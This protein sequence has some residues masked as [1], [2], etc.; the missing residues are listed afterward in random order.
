MNLLNL[1]S[2]LLYKIFF[3][4]DNI[5]IYY[6]LHSCY[7]FE[8]LNLNKILIPKYLI[9]NL[10]GEPYTN[11]KS[12]KLTSQAY[13]ELGYT[14]KEYLIDIAKL[15]DNMIFR[16]RI[17]DIFYKKFFKNT[18]NC[19]SNYSSTTKLESNNIIINSPLHIVYRIP[20]SKYKTFKKN[21][22]HIL[23]LIY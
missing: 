14:K 11:I 12:S 8:C 18:P 1:P 13:K 21:Y 15:I 10:Y 3:Y 16:D 6:I 23:A 4:L 2:E 22:Q 20:Y 17:G 19:I 5:H 7:K 9:E